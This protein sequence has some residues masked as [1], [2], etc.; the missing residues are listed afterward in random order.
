MSNEEVAIDMFNT[1][2]SDTRNFNACPDTDLASNASQTTVEDDLEQHTLTHSHHDD[3]TSSDDDPECTICMMPMSHAPDG[4]NIVLG[5][6]TLECNH[7]FHTHCIETWLSHNNH[8][9]L[10]RQPVRT[11]PS[12]TTPNRNRINIPAVLATIRPELRR[13]MFRQIITAAISPAAYIYEVSTDLYMSTY[14]L[15]LLFF[16]NILTIGILTPFV[17]ERGNVSMHTINRAQEVFSNLPLLRIVVLTLFITSRLLELNLLNATAYIACITTTL[18]LAD[19]FL[20]M[21]T[22]VP[23]RITLH[24]EN[25]LAVT[26]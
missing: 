23:A 10:C 26:M 7:T 5:T 8:C 17:K 14:A 18:S 2:L 3:S 9:P 24:G 1:G 19:D 12:S 20:A 4:E 16:M 11:T 21:T 25:Q 22:I 15:I 13:I 6:R